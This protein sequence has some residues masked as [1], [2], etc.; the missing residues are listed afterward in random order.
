MS[1]SGPDHHISISST[2]DFTHLG[3]S[4]QQ[5]F[6]RQD[7]KQVEAQ[8]FK[9]PDHLATKLKVMQ[10]NLETES[11][12]ALRQTTAG[13]VRGHSDMLKQEPKVENS[14]DQTV[15]NLRQSDFSESLI[16]QRDLSQVT[17]Q[18]G[19][20]DLSSSVLRDSKLSLELL[21]TGEPVNCT[22]Q[23]NIIDICITAASAM[24]TTK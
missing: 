21:K 18:N 22:V 17:V 13:Q 16:R 4:Q 15:S 12:A 1:I 7:F 9:T 3:P 5:V 8:N 20:A 6:A 23:S 19:Q 24:D 11:T 14:M 10:I 2:S